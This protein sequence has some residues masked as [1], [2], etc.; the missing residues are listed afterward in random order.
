VIY[1]NKM[2]YSFSLFESIKNGSNL[3][4][5]ASPDFVPHETFHEFSWVKPEESEW[6]YSIKRNS[7]LGIPRN[8]KFYDTL[9]SPLR[10]SVEILHKKGIPTTPSCSGHFNPDSFY[11]KIYKSLCSEEEGIRGKGINLKDPET[12]SRYSYKDPNYRIPWDE[13]SFLEISREHGKKGIIGI[14]DPMGEIQ[15]SLMESPGSDCQITRNGNLTFF[16]TSPKDK[17]SLNSSWEYF[18]D[19]I[20]NFF[21]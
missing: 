17:K 8:R 21:K 2:I 6:Y 3:L 9:D 15:R 19:S 13:K 11:N 20:K 16:I 18:N 12:N 7:P 5:K 4:D 14:L 1:K 10:E